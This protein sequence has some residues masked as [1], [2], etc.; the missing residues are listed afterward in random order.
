MKK[1]IFGSKDI[2]KGLSL[3]PLSQSSKSVRLIRLHRTRMDR[4]S[5]HL[6]VH[7]ISECP[8]FIALSYTWG[9]ANSTRTI[10]VQGQRYKIRENLW[11]AL[12]GILNHWDLAKKS[13]HS[14]ESLAEMYPEITNIFEHL[15]D[16]TSQNLFESGPLIWVDQICI[17]QKSIRER[18]HQVK[19]MKEIYSQAVVVISWLGIE[20]EGSKDALQYVARE[21][22]RLTTFDPDITFE[23]IEQLCK[24]PYWTRLWII[25]EIIVA[26]R[27]LIMSGLQVVLWGEFDRVFSAYSDIIE[28]RVASTVRE[29]QTLRHFRHQYQ[30]EED[31]IGTLDLANILEHCA[32]C[33]CSD[34]RDRIFGVCGLLVGTQLS[35][36]EVDYSLTRE[37]LFD[38]CVRSLAQSSPEELDEHTYY[39][40]LIEALELSHEHEMVKR[41]L[42]SL[43]I[44]R[45]EAER[46]VV[47]PKMETPKTVTLIVRTTAYRLFV[48]NPD[49]DI[50]DDNDTVR[51][52]ESSKGE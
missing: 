30:G 16:E 12:Q 23:A 47:T 20:G 21:R 19:M 36:I 34:V 6:E 26:K 44:S 1:P 51:E 7:S 32:K 41:V 13:R 10:Q 49:V 46:T 2:Y 22:L 11:Y 33:E 39:E 4:I 40:I 8:P 52:V 28:V 43:E 15:K 5:C 48:A 17:N 9:D 27:L 38:C 25:Q 24:R 42:K 31:E 18:N 3:N 14:N 45:H 35:A 29:L 50:I 37:K